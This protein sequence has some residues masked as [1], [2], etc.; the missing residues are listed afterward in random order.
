MNNLDEQ[1]VNSRIIIS[2]LWVAI[3]MIFAYVDIFGFFRADVLN[4]ALA[5]RVFVFDANQWF[6]LLTTIYIMIPSIM[7]FLTM[8]LKAKMT[9]ILNLIVPVLYTITIAGG[10]VGENWWYYQLGSAAEIILLLALVRYAWKWPKQA[11]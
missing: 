7:I 9:K 2:S 8:V 5:G 11:V 4:E 10:M 6:F 1:L 3:L